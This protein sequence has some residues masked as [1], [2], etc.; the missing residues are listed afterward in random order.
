MQYSIIYL[1][2]KTKSIE[3]THPKQVAEKAAAV[4]PLI[5]AFAVLPLEVRL[6]AELDYHSNY[7][8]AML[9][10][11]DLLQMLGSNSLVDLQ[12]VDDVLVAESVVLF[13]HIFPKN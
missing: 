1:K 8:A 9:P 12:Q 2:E 5:L 7:L 13:V 3:S 10:G 11:L 6:P 4:V